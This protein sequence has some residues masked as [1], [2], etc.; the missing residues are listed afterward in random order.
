MKASV[1][2]PA[3]TMSEF[4]GG[5]SCHIS[6]GAAQASFAP[7]TIVTMVAQQPGE[8]SDEQFHADLKRASKPLELLANKARK[9]MR[10]GTARKF[11]A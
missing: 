10:A 9:S 7:V 5:V 8:Y 1:I 3:I 4:V 2:Q 11:P 6:H